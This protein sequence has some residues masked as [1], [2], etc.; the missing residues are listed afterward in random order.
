M[1]Y[2]PGLKDSVTGSV[3]ISGVVSTLETSG[4]VPKVFDYI[5]ANYSGSTTDVYTYKTGGSGGTTVAV[6][7]VT[8]TT[9]GKTVLASVART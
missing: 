5:S 4:L 6:I 1:N 8:W 9:S 2:S 3:T 7:T